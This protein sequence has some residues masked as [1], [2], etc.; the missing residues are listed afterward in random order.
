MDKEGNIHEVCEFVLTK[1]P[2]CPTVTRMNDNTYV[3]VALGNAT[4]ECPG[5]PH[6]DMK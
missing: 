6:K 5:E 1:R 3:L 2:F 4:L